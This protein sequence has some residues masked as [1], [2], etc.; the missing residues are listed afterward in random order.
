MTSERESVIF[1]PFHIFT[2][3]EITESLKLRNFERRFLISRIVLFSRA[4][5]HST[6]GLYK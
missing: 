6:Y 5:C 2:D 1:G 3:V 4:F